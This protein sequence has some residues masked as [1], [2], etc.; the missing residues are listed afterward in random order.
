MHFIRINT[1][2]F[3]L[4]CEQNSVFIV[5]LVCFYI[6]HLSLLKHSDDV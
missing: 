4:L 2:V 6:C 1:S 5:H 3:L